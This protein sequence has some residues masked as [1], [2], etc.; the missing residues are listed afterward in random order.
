MG[1]KKYFKKNGNEVIVLDFRSGD[2]MWIYS[3]SGRIEKYKAQ[4]IYNR[5][6]GKIEKIKMA[7]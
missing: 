1:I 5:Y 2:A 6:N 4:I 3:D 7:A